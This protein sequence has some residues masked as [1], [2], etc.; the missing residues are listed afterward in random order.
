MVRA[1]Y[2]REQLSYGARVLVKDSTR[3]GIRNFRSTS[4]RRVGSIRST[5]SRE[6]LV[7]YSKQEFDMQLS[8]G[9]R[10]ITT[11]STTMCDVKS[12]SDIWPFQIDKSRYIRVKKNAKTNNNIPRKL[13]IYK[14]YKRDQFHEQDRSIQFRLNMRW[15]VLLKFFRNA[16]G[17]QIFL[18]QFFYSY[19]LPWEEGNRC[20]LRKK[21]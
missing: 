11:C 3:W 6:V 13:F 21:L 7:E 9:L 19:E 18:E 14:Q 8:H 16:K 12:F 15:L 20:S 4:M 5:A 2:N 17:T 10:A 1:E